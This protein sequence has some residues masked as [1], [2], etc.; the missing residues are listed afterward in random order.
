MHTYTICLTFQL[1]AQVPVPLKT[2]KLSDVCELVGDDGIPAFGEIADKVG[3]QR[4]DKT[5][6]S[7]G[8]PCPKQTMV[9]LPPLLLVVTSS[10]LVG[11]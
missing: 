10:N 6:K 5:V 3:A 2:A 1:L 7:E 8:S 9:P 11:K 4:T